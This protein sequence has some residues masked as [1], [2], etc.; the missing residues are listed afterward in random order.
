MTDTE[1]ERRDY[2]FKGV[3]KQDGG[4]GEKKTGRIWRVKQEVMRTD[5]YER[6]NR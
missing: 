3:R 4:G 2:T 5:R 6:I 1:R